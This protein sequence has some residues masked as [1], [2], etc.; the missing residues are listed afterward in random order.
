MSGR[1]GLLQQFFRIKGIVAVLNE[2]IVE[3]IQQGIDV[4]ANQ[5]RLWRKNQGFVRYIIRKACGF[6]DD[7]LE[8]EGLPVK[9]G[10]SKLVDW[11][12]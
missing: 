9:C 7:D 5:E 2:E 4:T 1:E 8:Q 11:I 10:G 6:V 12:A 3:Q